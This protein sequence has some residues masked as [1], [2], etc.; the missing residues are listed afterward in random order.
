MTFDLRQLRAFSVIVESGSLGRAAVLLNMT[1]PALSRIVSGLE[2]QI[3][4]RL[5]ERHSRGMRL[6]D[7]GEVLLPHATRLWQE[8]QFAEEDLRALLG[9]ARGTVRVGAIGSIACHPLP[10]AIGSL[11]RQRPNLRIQVVEDIWDRLAEAL[12]KYEVD[13]VFAAAIDHNDAIE[14]IETIRECQWEDTIRVVA[15][16][17]HPLRGRPGLTLAD[18]LD[19]PWAVPPKGSRPFEQMRRMFARQDLGLPQIGVETRSLATLKNL[20]IHSGFLGWMPDAMYEIE[21]KAGLMDKLTL[22][23][24]EDVYVLAAFKRRAGILPG[25]AAKLLDEI[26]MLTARQP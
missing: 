26:R 20:I 7:A 21:R 6:T 8:T 5:F 12:I 1:Q 17:A 22:T 3:G 18:T 9:Q 24:S 25:P 23:G 11:S 10:L 14:E 16:H 2:Q 15:G 13:L 4:A 19:L